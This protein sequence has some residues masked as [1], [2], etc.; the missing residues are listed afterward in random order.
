MGNKRAAAKPA[1]SRGG[2]LDPLKLIDDPHVRAAWSHA[3]LQAESGEQADHASGIVQ[4]LLLIGYELRQCRAVAASR[5]AD[6]GT[7]VF[8][9]PPLL[10]RDDLG[11]GRAAT[12]SVRKRPR[13][14]SKS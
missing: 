2:L 5:A 12:D 4:A 11:S 7:P 14:K 1:I 10:N 13:K 9:S 8:N 6:G 3:I